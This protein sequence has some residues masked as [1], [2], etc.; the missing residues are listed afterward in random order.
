[1]KKVTALL[2]VVILFLGTVPVM[3]DTKREIWV[4]MPSVTCGITEEE[5]SVNKA[6]HMGV[7]RLYKL[8]SI[9]DKYYLAVLERKFSDGGTNANRDHSEL[10]YYSLLET[11]DSFMV[12]GHAFLY[13]EYV[14]DSLEE[15]VDISA[16][17]DIAYYESQGYEAPIYIVNANGKYTC[18]SW[19]EANEYVI[20]GSNGG[21]TDICGFS[22]DGNVKTPY[23]YGNKFYTGQTRYLS[24]GSTYFYYLSDGRTKATV[25]NVCGLKN[26]ALVTISSTKIATADVTEENGYICY[27]DEGYT[28]NVKVDKKYKIS[29]ENDLYL[30]YETYENASTGVY[31]CS[32]TVNKIINGEITF[33]NK[34][35]F[36]TEKTSSVTYT[37]RLIKGLDK[38][39]YASENMEM[40]IASLGKVLITENGNIYEFT[41]SAYSNKSYCVY[42]GMLS[43]IT[44]YADN[45]YIRYADENGTNQYWQRI[46]TLNLSKGKVTVSED[47][48]IIVGA[49]DNLDGYYSSY[50]TFVACSTIATAKASS[51][52]EWWPHYLDSKF[53]D[54]RY[55]SGHW[56]ANE[57]GSYEI[58]YDIYDENDVKISTGPS[59]Y[60]IGASGQ[61]YCPKVR[62]FVINDTKVL[63]TT[64][65]LEYDVIEEYYRAA[66]VT[67]NDEG[68][69]EIPMPI[70]KKNI[71]PPDS[72]DTTPTEDVVDF[73]AENLELGFNVKENVLD[74]E[75]LTPELREQVNT[76]RLDSIVILNN[77]DYVSGKQNTGVTLETFD[78]YDDSFGNTP[79]R[80]Y[81]NGQYLCWYCD[82]PEKLKEGIYN[83]NYQVGQLTIC[84]VVKVIAPPT[85]NSATTVVF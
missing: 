39:Q 31:E 59:G 2:L 28:G 46:N 1:M 67:E 55:I 23:V 62:F 68:I 27:P 6:I 20:I 37:P 14:Q 19:D 42:N 73:A 36:S 41:S 64:D 49:H 43:Y 76:I 77:K 30:S 66:V 51:L 84:G 25:M 3:A 9:G 78:E 29:E 50:K 74:T 12:L 60:S 54:G 13:N 33:V 16:D 26:G 32:L 7:A 79:V 65:D 10:Y 72:A 17:I 24:S 48:D 34:K 45:N 52:L 63:L 58:W 85:N 5:V 69:V 47:I 44:N 71:T 80:F 81:S 56:V 18:S 82:Q 22:G 15:V 61:R 38:N 83:I 8:D 70:G 40:P 11:E 53:S 57:A 21:I 75:N 35:T 4:P